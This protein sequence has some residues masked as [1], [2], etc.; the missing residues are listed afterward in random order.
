MA[1]GGGGG[2]TT[3]LLATATQFHECTT[4]LDQPGRQ[5]QCARLRRA[6]TA[7]EFPPLPA[8]K[9][10]NANVLRAFARTKVA[11]DS[12]QVT[13]QTPGSICMCRLHVLLR[14]CA[15]TDRAWASAPDSSGCESCWRSCVTAAG[16][17]NATPRWTLLSCSYRS[18][19]P[20]PTPPIFCIPSH[21]GGCVNRQGESGPAD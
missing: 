9:Q 17:Q 13:S 18:P 7:M 20:L 8:V 10:L 1:V 4:R 15:N 16:R 21:F 6:R 11:F 14:R 2:S 19:W 5:Q 3:A 12:N